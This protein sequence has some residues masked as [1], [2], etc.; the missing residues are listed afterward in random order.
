[1]MPA[2]LSSLEVT[3]ATFAIVE[4]IVYLG[5][6]IDRVSAMIQGFAMEKTIH[7]LLFKF[8]SGDGSRM[9]HEHDR[10]EWCDIK[11]A[12]EKL[13][14]SPIGEV[15]MIERAERWLARHGG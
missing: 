9:D 6:L 10:L 15:E 3:N 4:P 14:G 7:Y 2:W 12:L 5:A 11:Q 1:M 8:V 13:T